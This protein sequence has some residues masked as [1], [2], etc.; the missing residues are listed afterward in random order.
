MSSKTKSEL[1]EEI[2]KLQ[3]QIQRLKSDLQGRDEQ[4]NL[5]KTVIS[6]GICCIKFD[7]RPGVMFKTPSFLKVGV[8][9]I[10]EKTEPPPE[11]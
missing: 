3:R 8:K 2:E 9:Y 11:A 6:E 10:Q 1:I 5:F 4:Y 7:P